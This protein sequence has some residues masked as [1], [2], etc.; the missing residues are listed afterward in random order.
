MMS[1][2]ENRNLLRLIHSQAP[3]RVCDNG[4]WSDTWFAGHGQVF[5]IAVVPGVEVQMKVYPQTPGEPRITIHAE[6]YG[7]RYSIEPPTG[8]YSKHPLIEAAMEY[9][10]IPHGVAVEVSI[11]SEV[12][13]GCSTGT[14]A[15]VST[16]L[17]GALD[18]LRGGRLAAHEVALAAQQ[19]ETQM[20][21]LQCGIQDQIA[22]AHGGINY[23]D[24]Y[25][26][27]HASVSRLHV[28][29]ALLWELE[30]R[31]SLVFVGQS[32]NSSDVHKQVIAELQRGGSGESK[33]EP[34][35]RCAREAKE[36]LY[37]GDLPRLG[38]S[39]IDNTAAQAALHPE[40]V[41]VHHR[42]IIELAKEHNAIGWKVNGAGGEGGSITL[43]SGPDYAEKRA[44]MQA[45][46]A[47]GQYREIP[48]RLSPEGLRVWESSLPDTQPASPK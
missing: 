14:S 47:N 42:A 21:G 41:G 5:H 28:P 44:M 2:L 32:H 15:A 23:I 33:L 34:I 39:M 46:E 20:L 27:P 25:Q 16:A 30:A 17:I 1:G 13:A 11:H 43:L 31:L 3:I 12:P 29:E 19:I 48:I 7:D 8:I 24:M 36:A 22:S 35:R 18:L 37:A 45:I 4:G 38:R 40:L 10:G 9:M 26:Y 6:N